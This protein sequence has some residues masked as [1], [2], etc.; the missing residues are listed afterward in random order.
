MSDEYSRLWLAV[1]CIDLPLFALKCD[2]S[3]SCALVVK[4]KRVVFVSDGALQL[5]AHEGMDITTAQLLTGGNVFE[6]DEQREQQVLDELSEQLYQFTPYIECY[7][8]RESA[9]SGLLLE[10]SSCLK[11]F[12]G[13][14]KMTDLIADFLAATGLGFSFGLATN[15]KA[16][17]YLS[18]VSHEIRGDETP[19]IFFERLCALPIGL[20]RDFPKVVESL[21]KTGFQS[22]GDVARQIEVGSLAVFK[23]RFG[24]V[25]ADFLCNLF[26]IDQDF[27]QGSLFVQPRSIYQPEEWFEDEIQFECPVTVVAQLQPAIEALL[28][29]LSAYLRLRQQ[30]CQY[31]EWIIADIYRRKEIISVNCDSPQSY[32]QLLY[33]LTLIQFENKELPFEVDSIKL[34][35]RQAMVLQNSSLALDFEYGRKQKHSLADFAVTIAKL[36]ARLGED[37]VYKLSYQDSRVPELTNAMISLAEKSNQG[38][39]AIH[40]KS[41]RPAWLLLKPELMEERN[42]RLFWRG[43]IELLVGPERIIGDWWEEPVARDYYMAKRH[44]HLRLWIFFNLYDKRWYVHGVFS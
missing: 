42:Q 5:G 14:K 43:Y 40:Q 31:I 33:D 23:K 27:Q 39:P 15:A 32:W 38:L 1:R 37:A 20:L 29:N 35:C 13:L 12:F 26:E 41:L 4:K 3:A 7:F 24:R 9:Q 30:Q 2:E 17:W 8:S 25:F 22:L 19:A 28:Q 36:K 21:S 11:L 10:I 44:D 18:F 16:A 6:R 34:V